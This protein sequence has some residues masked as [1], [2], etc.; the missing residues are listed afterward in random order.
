MKGFI[1]HIIGN[2]ETEAF[3]YIPATDNKTYEVGMALSL[4]SN[5]VTPDVSGAFPA[6]LCRT[7]LD[8]P[9]GGSGIVACTPVRADIEYETEVGENALATY[10]AGTAVDI[11]TD[12]MTVTDKDS[13]SNGSFEIVYAEGGT[14]GDK[15]IV[16]PIM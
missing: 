11:D 7:K 5:K 9:S 16:R 1:P 12:G 8:I 10:S 6:Y 14:A 4:S 15:V 3:Y 2:T 13:Q